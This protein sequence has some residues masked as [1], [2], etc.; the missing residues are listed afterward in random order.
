M[1]GHWVNQTSPGKAGQ[2]RRLKHPRA[3]WGTEPNMEE[4][5]TENKK[6]CREEQEM[7]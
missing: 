5:T 6:T 3:A 2:S 1:L 4:E 7:Q